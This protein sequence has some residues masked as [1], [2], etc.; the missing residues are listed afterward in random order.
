LTAAKHKHGE[1]NEATTGRSE[2]GDRQMR[3]ATGRRT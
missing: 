2:R 3:E 1:V